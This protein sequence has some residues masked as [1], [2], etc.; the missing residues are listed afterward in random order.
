MKK[1]FLCVVL[2]VGISAIG[3]PDDG[4]QGFKYDIWFSTGPAFGNYFINGSNLERNYT[5][6]PGF[7]L[8]L[9]TLFGD[10][11]I[12][13]FFNYGILFPMDTNS[14]RSHGA[15]VQ[16]DF[17]LLGVAFGYNINDALKIYFGIGPDMNMLFLHKK[18][19]SNRTGDYS[20]AL[21]LG[22]NIGLKFKVTDYFIISFGTTLSYNFAAY[23]E[24]RHNV[25]FRHYQYNIES[26]GWV[27][28]YSMI[29]IKPYISF[30]V[31]IAS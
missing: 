23:R 7:D 10:R 15:S 20:I 6:S 14:G 29:G 11:N 5:G 18:E 9:F 27:N 19:G 24:I 12:G 1:L 31:N 17:I 3:F 4:T 21:G 22:G 26:A 16:L 30:G 25:S 13:F 8:S 2:I 28:G